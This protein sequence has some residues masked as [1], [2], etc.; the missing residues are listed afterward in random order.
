MTMQLKTNSNRALATWLGPET[1]YKNNDLD[2]GRF[3]DFVDEYAKEHGPELEEGDLIREISSRLESQD[4]YSD[5]LRQ[6]VVQRVYLASNILDFLKR[7]G[8]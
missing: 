3:Y 8:R 6:T 5:E 4:R 2:M 1:W 7:S